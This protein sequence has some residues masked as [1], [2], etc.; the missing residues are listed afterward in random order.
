MRILDGSVGLSELH[1]GH[2]VSGLANVSVFSCKRQREPAELATGGFVRCNTLLASHRRW[3]Q[4]SDANAIDNARAV[5]LALTWVMRAPNEVSVA[6]E[7]STE[8]W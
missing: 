6:P 2:G 5:M 8:T 4:L 3:H 1:A 7:G